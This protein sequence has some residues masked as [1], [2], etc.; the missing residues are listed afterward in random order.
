MKIN[1]H[2]PPVSKYRSTKPKSGLT[3]NK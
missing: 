2:A 3:Y 1:R